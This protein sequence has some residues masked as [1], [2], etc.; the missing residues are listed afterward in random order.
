MI[1]AL[2]DLL[3]ATL[4][5]GRARARMIG[6]CPPHEWRE[7]DLFCQRCGKYPQDLPKD[8]RP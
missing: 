8:E 5:L 7:P 2:L 6:H 4:D 1:R 3:T